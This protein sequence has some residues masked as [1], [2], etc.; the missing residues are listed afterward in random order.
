MMLIAIITLMPLP[1]RHFHACRRFR[2]RDTIIAAA[3]AASY[4]C[5]YY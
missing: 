4:Y 1:P 5:H 2:F 3:D